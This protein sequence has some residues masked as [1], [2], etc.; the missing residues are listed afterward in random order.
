MAH[1]LPYSSWASTPFRGFWV[2]WAVFLR[3][4]LTARF[5]L[6]F[7]VSMYE[8]P[9]STCVPTLDV[10]NTLTSSD[11][12]RDA[13]LSPN[14]AGKVILTLSYRWSSQPPRSAPFDYNVTTGLSWHSRARLTYIG[15]VG[16]VWPGTWSLE[17]PLKFSG[18]V[19]RQSILWDTTWTETSAG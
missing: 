18:N 11:K 1:L 15:N 9:G 8:K 3:R 5:Y 4:T 14:E 12:T 6:A 7:V 19:L 17:T 13:W 16:A 10:A 2:T